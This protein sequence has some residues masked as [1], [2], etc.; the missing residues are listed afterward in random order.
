MRRGLVRALAVSSALGVAFLL[1]TT[2]HVWITLLV[3]GAV[4]TAP[5]PM[6]STPVA[7]AAPPANGHELD[8]AELRAR[9]VL[10]QAGLDLS[11]DIRVF[12]T[13]NAVHIEGTTPSADQQRI[14]RARLTAI[15]H[16]RT[17]LHIGQP[18]S[19]CPDE[20][21]KR[22]AMTRPGL[23]QWLA[24]TFIDPASRTSFRSDLMRSISAVHQRLT[25]LD[26]LARRYPNARHQ[27]QG[28]ELDLFQKLVALHYAKLRTELD[29]A[30]TRI[31][32][33]AGSDSLVLAA[34]TCPAT[35]PERTTIALSNATT[36]ERQLQNLLAQHDLTATARQRVRTTFQSLWTSMYAPQPS[37]AHNRPVTAQ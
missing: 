37:T 27:L 2:Q 16:V 36:L 29:A 10:A 4:P 23:D 6:T 35:W 1:W 32:V 24:H 21:A 34:S 15:D 25:L 9:L 7:P 8:R 17:D 26:A 22:A 13:P 18:S 11:G 31:S 14:A 20:V 33:L 3:P 5:T 28:S 30:K 19:T 12:R